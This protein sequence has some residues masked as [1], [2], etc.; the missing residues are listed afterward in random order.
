M[1]KV[2]EQWD[3]QDHG[4]LEQ[5]DDGILTVAGTIRMPLGNFPRRMTVAKLAAG[6]SVVYSAIALREPEMQRLEQ[7]GPPAFMVVPNAH[8][9]LDAKIWKQRYP[10]LCVVAPAGARKE[11]EDVVPVDATGDV[12]DDASVKL[13]PIAGV[14]DSE[15][16]LSI[17]R[18]GGRTLVTNDVI[19]HVVHPDGLGAQVMA[20]LMGFGVHGPQ[21]PRVAMHWIEDK[22]ALAA[23]FREWAADAR[24]RR[25]VVSHGDVVEQ[26]RDA[27]LG[28][29]DTLDR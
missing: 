10:D 20:R 12:F 1:T 21:I 19:A 23:Q 11:V 17:E 2:L 18:T 22:A 4:P 9:R 29:A 25:I 6:G 8:H 16:G 13:L 24:L 3:V 15:V 14:G 26:P 28:L 5:V 7:F 27:L